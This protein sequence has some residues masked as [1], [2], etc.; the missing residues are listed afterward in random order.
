MSLTGHLADP[1]SAVRRYLAQTFPNL[2]ALRLT[3]AERLLSPAHV[4]GAR[5]PDTTPFPTAE[6]LPPELPLGGWYPWGTV[7]TAFDYRLRY[8]LEAADPGTLV[9]ASGARLLNGAARGHDPAGVD[10]W[11]ELAAALP[12]PIP[13]VRPVPLTSAHDA[14][15]ARL[16]VVLAWF[17]QLYRIG[18]E[19]AGDDHPIVGAGPKATLSQVLDLV[20]DR[21]VSD[22]QA[23]T[24]L[25][26][27]THR[28]MLDVD[29][30]VMNPTFARSVDLGGADADLVLDGLLLEVKTSK[31]VSLRAGV[32][33]QL[34]GYLLADTDDR[35]DIETVGLY[36]ARHGLLW[37]WPVPWFLARLAGRDLD[38]G[39]ARA[40]FATACEPPP[41]RRV[42]PAATVETP[43]RL[44]RYGP[45]TRSGSR[46]LS[47]LPLFPPVSGRG[48]WHAL[49][50]DARPGV[51]RGHD[52]EAACR[53]GLLL[54]VE[55]EPL[56]PAD[57]NAV[58][59][60][61][62]CQLCS[63]YTARPQLPAPPALLRFYPP[64]DGGRQWHVPAGDT[65][66]YLVGSGD[67]PACSTPGRLDRSAEAV[68]ITVGVGADAGAADAR[69]CRR[70]VAA[71]T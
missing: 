8:L 51:P 20:E 70:C 34:L 47:R 23:M 68:V 26:T 60:P 19:C 65:G 9:A 31:R 29:V 27:A 36:W 25:V 37:T 67:A 43:G 35:Y 59:G 18:L 21:L 61:R 33:W 52:R 17:E 66:Y 45:L 7:G 30:A 3:A 4:G 15:L 12:R 39:E 55:R 49:A 22:V 63:A 11:R 57:R 53:S 28:W 44:A 42:L 14:D 6:L 48:M 2:R 64:K 58:G 32:V 38:L 1:H 13:G 10:L 5:V 24:G 56:R 69:L 41:P 62:V 50:A 16:C 71:F 46:A 54:D 40:G